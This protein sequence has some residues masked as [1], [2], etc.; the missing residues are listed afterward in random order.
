MTSLRLSVDRIID[1]AQVVIADKGAA[2]FS[3]RSLASELGVDPMAV[4]HYFPNK[5]AI[6][7]GVLSRAMTQIDTEVPGIAWQQDLAILCNNMRRFAQDHPQLFLVFCENDPWLLPEHKFY[8][9]LYNVFRKSG[10]TKRHMAM[11]LRLTM[12]FLEEFCYCEAMGWHD[13]DDEDEYIKSLEGEPFPLLYEMMSETLVVNSDEDF[14]FGVAV[15]TQGLASF[16]N[17]SAG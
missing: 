5:G 14:S 1:A 3:M 17:Q 13:P 15:L 12:T 7:Q 6:I 8:E 11:S 9:A 16:S 10:M 4:Y 2:R